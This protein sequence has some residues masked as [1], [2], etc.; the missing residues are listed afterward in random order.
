M[1]KQ[2]I[3]NA[4]YNELAE[5]AAECTAEGYPSHGSNYELRTENLWRDY[6]DY[7]Y[8]H[9]T[10]QVFLHLLYP[11]SLRQRILFYHKDSYNFDDQK[12][13]TILTAKIVQ[14]LQKTR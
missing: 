3:L 13:H 1:T 12:F 5:I 11:L 2:E 10:D 8:D 6:Y 7:D 9:A 4:Y 14:Q